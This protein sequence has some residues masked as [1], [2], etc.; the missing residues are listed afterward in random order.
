VLKAGFQKSPLQPPTLSGVAVPEIDLKCSYVTRLPV[1]VAT[2]HTPRGVRR[3][4]HG[5][6]LTRI[7]AP[8]AR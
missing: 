3:A 7:Q 2:V 1:T 6:T 5:S 4:V 8:K